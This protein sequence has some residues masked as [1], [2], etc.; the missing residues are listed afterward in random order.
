MGR[1]LNKAA[2]GLTHR[3]NAFIIFGLLL[4]QIFCREHPR[5]IEDLLRPRV[6]DFITDALWSG[7]KAQAVERFKD[8]FKASFSP[9]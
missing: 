5:S 2:F 8:H 4:M 6:P 1:K 9:R 7:C 3:L